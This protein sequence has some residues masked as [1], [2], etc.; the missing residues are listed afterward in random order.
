VMVF[1][2]TRARNSSPGKTPSGI[3]TGCSGIAQL[4][5]G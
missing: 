3:T 2:A 4:V 5:P 1:P